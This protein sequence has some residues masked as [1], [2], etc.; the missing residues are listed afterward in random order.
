MSSYRSSYKYFNWQAYLRQKKVYSYCHQKTVPV[1]VQCYLLFSCK[2]E[3]DNTLERIN[4]LTTLKRKTG[5]HLSLNGCKVTML[6][7]SAWKRLFHIIIKD[8]TLKSFDVLYSKN[9]EILF[10]M[11]TT[12]FYEY[13]I[14]VFRIKLHIL[15]VQTQ[16]HLASTLLLTVHLYPTCS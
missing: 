2:L 14:A 1:V 13:V 12:T 16:H 5:S 3:S 11:F 4:I 6:S 8:A 9:A 7:A 15:A 10:S